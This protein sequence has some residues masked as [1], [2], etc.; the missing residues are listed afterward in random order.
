MKQHVSRTRLRKLPA[1]WLVGLSGFV[2]VSALTVLAG[3]GGGGGSVGDVPGVSAAAATGRATFTVTWPEQRSTRLIPA[4]ANSIRVELLRG[5]V[6]IASQLLVRPEAGG[7]ATL[8]FTALPVDKLTA[9]AFAYPGADGSG[10]AQ[11]AGSVPV[12]IRSGETVTFTLTLTSTIDHLALTPA[13][14]RLTVGQQMPLMVTAWDA[15]G[16]AGGIVLLSPGKL[17]WDSSD[18]AVAA[19]DREGVVTA[20]SAGTTTITVTDTESGRSASVTV[21]VTAPPTPTPTPTPTPDPFAGVRE[22]LTIDPNAALP[23]YANPA[24]PRHYDAATL[25]RDNT[26]PDNRV[27]DRGATLG[28]VLFFDKRLSVNN[29]ISCASCHQQANGL[30]DS[31]RFSVGFNGVDVT[32]AHSMRLGNLRFYAGRSMF[33][34]R[35]AASAE[36]QALQPIQD[37]VEMGFDPAHGGLA[38]LREKMAS[39]PY[40]P[41]LFR[42]VY[43]DPA[44]T[45][46]RIRRALAQYVRSLV[47]VNSRFDTGFAQVFDPA[48]PQRGV[49]RPFPGYTAQEERGKQLFFGAPG[50]DGAGCAGCHQAPTFALDPNSR[51]NGLDA[52]ETRVFKSPSLKSVALAGPYMHDGRV[53]TLEEVVDHYIRGVQDGP[54]LD[55]RLRDGQGRPQR[56]PLTVADRDALVAFLKT[57][58]DEALAQDP[59]FSD[60]FRR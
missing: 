4:A 56:L 8:T 40:Y 5:G 45:D 58:D 2:I 46:D 9:R 37:S 43:G 27:T 33:W 50:R 20:V 31:R 51:S 23:N 59:K 12:V 10:V 22:Y 57:L 3:C 34:D 36:D 32:G 44:I 1:E 21:I 60:P 30:T 54:A 7:A 41:E 6:V 35:R 14:P 13:Q 18:P 24:Y 29:A 52:G 42:W 39:L 17:T 25:A 26:P 11:A 55:N 47:S 49:Q 28:R 48:A 15:P 19:V 16:D 38:A 53:A